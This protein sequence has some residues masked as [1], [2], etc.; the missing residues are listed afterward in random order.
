MSDH[1]AYVGPSAASRWP[2]LAPTFVVESYQNLR[3]RDDT[4]DHLTVRLSQEGVAIEYEEGHMGASSDAV[5]PMTP[6][7]WRKM[8][9]WCERMAKEA[10]G[11]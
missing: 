8:A 3:G 5:V 1:K 4:A 9:A 2:T 6:K 11:E 10:G 7:Q